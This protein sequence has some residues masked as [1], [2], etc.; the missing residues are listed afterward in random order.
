MDRRVCSLNSNL[1]KILNI[2]S[3]RLMSECFIKDLHR[4]LGGNFSGL[5][6]ANP[7]RN[8]KKPPLGIG[9]KRIL[10]QRPLFT[11]SSIRY[12]SRLNIQLGLLFTH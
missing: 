11:Q 12:R 7:I 9:E 2:Y 4:S 6:A 8:G 5:R 3:N 1:H 10:V